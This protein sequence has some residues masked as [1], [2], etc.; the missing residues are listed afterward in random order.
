MVRYII[1]PTF[2]TLF[3]H[4]QERCRDCPMLIQMLKNQKDGGRYYGAICASPAVVLEP[5]GL[6]PSAAVAYPCFMDKISRKGEGR[7]VVSD[8][9]VTS[10][11]PGS[12]MEFALKIVELLFG[13]EVEKNVAA[14][15]CMP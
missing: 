9:C 7:V 13:E 15:L 1:I 4:M 3:S 6:C 8:K 5:N 14:G 10:I 2:T 11:G 12:A